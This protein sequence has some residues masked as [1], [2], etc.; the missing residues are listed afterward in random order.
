VSLDHDEL[1][2]LVAASALD[3]VDD[4]EERL[5]QDHVRTCT[6]CRADLVA[7][8]EVAARLSYV[9]EE[10]PSGVWQRI[11]AATAPSPRP[12]LQLVVGEAGSG[13]R[14]RMRLLGG[15]A[16]AAVAV[17]FAL[18]AAGVVS[19]SGR[20]DRLQSA[21]VQARVDRSLMALAFDPN[22]RR[23]DLTTAAGTTVA[24]VALRADGSGF[25][26]P[27]RLPG[28]PADRTYQAWTI[29][30]GR[31]RSIGLLSTGSAALSFRAPEAPVTVAVTIEPRGGSARPSGAPIAS[32]QVS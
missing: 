12:P 32:G 7:F 19:Q 16:G 21:V 4:E 15:L 10:A 29:R 2:D 6:R 27:L 28:L 26:V 20:I 9:G 11:A 30:G 25:L 31:A 3:A 14:P 8:R 1:R 18:L 23:A 5:V 24:V 13:R 22:A 17:G